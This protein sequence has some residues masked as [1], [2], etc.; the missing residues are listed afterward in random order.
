MRRD[1]LERGFEESL[2]LFEQRARG[3]Q[4]LDPISNGVPRA[5]HRVPAAPALPLP[6]GEEIPGAPE[7]SSK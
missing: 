1:D 4:S 7:T 5:S 6:F 3:D 2:G